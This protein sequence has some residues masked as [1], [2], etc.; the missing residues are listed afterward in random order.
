MRSRK[1]D[2]SCASPISSPVSKRIAICDALLESAEPRWRPRSSRTCTSAPAAASAGGTRSE[3]YT[4]KCPPRRRA[5][6]RWFTVIA[7]MET[8][9]AKTSSL[10][11]KTYLTRKAVVEPDL[12]SDAFICKIL[13]TYSMLFI[14]LCLPNVTSKEKNY[15]PFLPGEEHLGIPAGRSG[16]LRI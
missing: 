4:H 3:R 11:S 12:D 9:S 6:P 10:K 13:L 5:A 7:G 1:N 14:T 16:G 8:V 15:G 2:V